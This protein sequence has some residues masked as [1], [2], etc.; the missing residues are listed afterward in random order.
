MDTRERVALGIAITITAV[1][2]V[3]VIVAT[4]SHDSID[5]AVTLVMMAAVGWI[6]A[7]LGIRRIERNGDNK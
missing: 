6:A 7:Y 5:P 4:F 1:W 3:V 2:V